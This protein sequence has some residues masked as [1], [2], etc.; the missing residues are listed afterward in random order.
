VN[1]ATR[2]LKGSTEKISGDGKI[3]IRW[4][5]E[6]PLTDQKIIDE[7]IWFSISPGTSKNYT[8]YSMV[9]GNY[10]GGYHYQKV[11]TVNSVFRWGVVAA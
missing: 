11:I 3:K 2:N 6:T 8:M 4:V 9:A 10:F 5:K 7:N 1:G